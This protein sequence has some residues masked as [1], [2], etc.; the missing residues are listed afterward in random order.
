[1][2][3][4][5]RWNVD[6]PSGGGIAI[7]GRALA[8]VEALGG[9]GCCLGERVSYTYRPTLQRTSADDRPGCLCLYRRIL[10]YV[11]ACLYTASTTCHYMYWPCGESFWSAALH[12]GCTAGVSDGLSG[13]MV[14]LSPSPARQG[15]GT[16]AARCLTVAS[17]LSLSW[18]LYRFP[19]MCATGSCL[20]LPHLNSLLLLTRLIPTTDCIRLGRPPPRRWD[21]HLFAFTIAYASK[22]G[23]HAI[24]PQTCPPYRR[25]H[26]SLI[27]V[28]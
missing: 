28:R 13:V 5:R 22:C 11:G 17:T 18:C 6:G 7:V 1:M 19:T 24:R 15:L 14:F 16:W 12:N 4:G 20:C 27:R 8:L 10:A 2:G 26:T 25:Y 9:R 23:E 21:L 3:T